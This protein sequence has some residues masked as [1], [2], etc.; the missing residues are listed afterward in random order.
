MASLETRAGLQPSDK[1]LPYTVTTAQVEQYLQKKVDVL[2]N[3]DKSLPQNVDVRVYTT[4]VGSK[5]IP[6]VVVLP[7]SVLVDKSKKQ[8]ND[9]ID[10]IFNINER[11]S[12]VEDLLKPFKSLFVAYTYDSDDMKAFSSSDWRRAR[13]VART[14][15]ESLKKMV[16][17]RISQFRGEGGRKTT[18]V[19]FL[20]DPLRVFHDMLKMNDDNRDFNVDIERWQKI[21]TGE[22]R[23]IMTR[24]VKH[25]KHKRYNDT[26]IANELNRKMRGQR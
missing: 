1:K 2:C 11:S 20:L 22:F 18:V 26:V 3:R 6:F 4:E 7:T 23:Y 17:P 10:G 21:K 8:N 14:T 19:I 24:S 25:G 15:S 9:H 5:F 16:F 13:G 12:K